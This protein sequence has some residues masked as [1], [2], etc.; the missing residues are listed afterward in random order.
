MFESATVPLTSFSHL[1]NL[2]VFR[3]KDAGN[4]PRKNAITALGDVLNLI[5]SQEL[6]SPMAVPEWIRKDMNCLLTLF[7]FSVELSR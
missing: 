6:K 3:D 7:I 2:M 4:D 5:K 1:A